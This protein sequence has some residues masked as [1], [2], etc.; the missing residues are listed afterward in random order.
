M[1]DTAIMNSNYMLRRLDLLMKYNYNSTVFDV[2]KRL[3]IATRAQGIIYA[4]EVFI[5]NS[6]EMK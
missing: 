5:I 1:I 3:Q 6:G 4:R 2:K